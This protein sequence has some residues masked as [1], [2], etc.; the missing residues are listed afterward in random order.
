MKTSINITKFEEA[1]TLWVVRD[2]VR[3][4]GQVDGTDLCVLEVEVPPGS[5]TPPHR[6]ESVEIFRILNG[7]LT[8]GRFDQGQPDYISAGPGT[9]IT[10]PSQAP[11]HYVNRGT[12]DVLMLV[13]VQRSLVEFFRELARQEAPPGGP[14]NEAELAGVMAACARHSIG[15]LS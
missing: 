2:R 5:G 10:V 6:H 12:E 4:M 15:I 9:V 1:E 14:P 7:A 11:H 8:F 13:V 3:F